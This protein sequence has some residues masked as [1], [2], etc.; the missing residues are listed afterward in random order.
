VP[1]TRPE[2]AGVNVTRIAATEY[3]RERWSNGLGWTREIARSPAVGDF[4]WRVSIAEVDR[5][6]PFSVFPGVEREIVLLSATGCACTSATIRR[7]AAPAAW[8]T[9]LFRRTRGARRTARRPDHRLQPD[10]A[11]GARARDAAASPAG[12][13]MLFFAEP[14]VQWLVTLA[15]RSRHR[16]GRVAADTDGAGRHRAD[17][18]TRT[19]VAWSSKGGG[20]L[21]LARLGPPEA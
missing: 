12:R 16:Q 13:S 10:V 6:A 7:R 9:A 19:P 18:R 8:T 3:R 17:R 2:N 5:D 20:E 21:L 11:A 15:G 1:A 14:G 4:D